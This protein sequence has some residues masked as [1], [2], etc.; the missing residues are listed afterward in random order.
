[1]LQLLLDRLLKELLKNKAGVKKCSHECTM[2]SSVK[3]LIE[4]ESNAIRYMAGY[5]AVSRLKKYRKPSRDP[6]LSGMFVRVL[7]GM[8]AAD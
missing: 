3:P 4:M 6:R 5:V 8:K 2:T 7:M 1:M